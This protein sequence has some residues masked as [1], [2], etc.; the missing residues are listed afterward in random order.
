MKKFMQIVLATALS[1]F[2]MG[3]VAASV[4]DMRILANTASDDARWS[5]Y[6][7]DLAAQP[8]LTIEGQ[9]IRGYDPE[10]GLVSTAAVMRYQCLFGTRTP[11]IAQAC[12]KPGE[13][14]VTF[15]ARN[16]W[17]EVTV[18]AAALREKARGPGVFF[19]LATV[20]AASAPTAPAPAVAPA[21]VGAASATVMVDRRQFTKWVNEVADTRDRQIS[22][23]NAM[24]TLQGKLDSVE[25]QLHAAAA[26]S[27]SLNELRKE[28]EET[29]AALAN[30]EA[31]V[32]SL[33]GLAAS[34]AEQ[35]TAP[36]IKRAAEA[37]LAANTAKE[38][39]RQLSETV[40]G[41][42]SRF[43]LWVGLLAMVTIG[44]FVLGAV[45]Y[46]I[47]R[48]TVKKTELDAFAKKTELDAFV[49]DVVKSEAS[50][51]GLASA[52]AHIK[53][54]NL[55]SEA[56]RQA[57]V[58]VQ[59]RLRIMNNDII[60]VR[61]D[62]DRHGD[63]LDRHGA[64]LEEHTQ[65]LEAAAAA[66]GKSLDWQIDQDE[67]AAI[68]AS[69]D[70]LRQAGDHSDTPLLL[71]VPDGDAVKV[72][73]VGLELTKDGRIRIHGIQPP[74]GQRPVD[75]GRGNVLSALRKAYFAGRLTGVPAVAAVQ[76]V[77]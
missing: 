3:Q 24:A 46:F 6:L 72:V 29:K 31:K 77:A 12:E 55:T 43:E 39:V 10:T 41:K 45:W 54:L 17:T 26:T 63:V 30:Q 61:N 14:F 18:P 49:Q 35:S 44:L 75:V 37:L 4:T 7:S 60:L 19:Q 9:V 68:K 36:A 20:A 2:M 16:G 59:E 48:T 62:V 5:A 38:D 52:A 32:A 56:A 22:H 66:I 50:A 34:A 53:N 51:A 42:A 76:Q 57:A 40:A 70:S 71:S 27:T 21:A 33:P 58:Q 13:L 11:A 47:N 28:Y 69:E 73:R 67:A 64:R 8:P 25:R 23:A 74:A 1:V 65:Q 15:V